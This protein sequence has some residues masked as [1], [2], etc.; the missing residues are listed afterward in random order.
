MYG[1]LT[2]YSI[3]LLHGDQRG[4]ERKLFE[5]LDIGSKAKQ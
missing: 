2:I 5:M 3:D 1:F 4:G